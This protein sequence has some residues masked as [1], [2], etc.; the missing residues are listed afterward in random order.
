M[1]IGLKIILWIMGIWLALLIILQIVLTTPVLTKIVNSFAAEYIDGDVRFGKVSISMF[2]K[3]PRAELTFEDFSITYPSERYENIKNEGAQGYLMNEGCG[4]TADTLASFSHLSASINL[5][6]LLTGE[7]KIPHLNLDS[8]RIFIHRYA[9]GSANWDVF[10]LEESED[11]E[12]TEIPD[13]S[14]G[15]IAL[16]KHPYIVYTDSKD[17]LF[18][19]ISSKHIQMNGDLDIQNFSERKVGLSIDSTFIAGRI[20]ADTLALGI[21]RLHLHENSRERAVDINGKLGLYARTQSFGRL[22]VPVDIS[23]N[24]SFPQNE[25]PSVN[26]NDLNIKLAHIPVKANGELVF[27]EDRTTTHAT[28]EIPECG[29]SELKDKFI[30]NFIPEAAKIR[31]DAKISM[32]FLCEGDYIYETG[33]LPPILAQFRLPRAE[34]SHSDIPEEVVGIAFEANAETDSKG[35]LSVELTELQ[36]DA[37]GLDLFAS[38]EMNDVLHSDPKISIDGGIYAN[39]DSLK[40]FIPDSLGIKAHGTLTALVNGDARLSQLNLYNFSESSLKGDLLGENI[41]LEMPEDSI[42]A[43][44]QGLEA[45]LGPEEKTSRRDASKTIQLV[46]IQVKAAKLD[47][48]YGDIFRLNTEG[49]KITAKNTTSSPTVVNGR[50]SYP[51]SGTIS[52]EKFRFRDSDSTAIVLRNTRNRFSIRQKKDKFLTPVLTLTSRNDRIFAR[53]EAN[54]AMLA[55]AHIRVSAEIKTKEKKALKEAYLDSLAK[56]YP[57]IQRDS[58][59]RHNMAQKRAGFVLPDWLSEK[60]FRE[61]DIDIALNKSIARYFREWDISGSLKMS[62]GGI[63]TP[64]FPMQTKLDTF[65]LRF[66]NDKI[67]IDKARVVA[68]ASELSAH[69]K[70]T[71]LQRAL[72]GRKGAL[73]LN[74]DIA[75]DS[76]DAGELLVAYA[77][78]SKVNIE[79]IKTEDQIS[80]SDFTEELVMDTTDIQIETPLIVIPA[81]LNA[82]ISLNARGLRYNTLNIDSLQAQI[83]M[84]ER[85]VQLTDTHAATSIGDVSLEGFYGTRTKQDLKTGFSAEIKNLTAERAINLIPSL[86]TLVP[87]LKS[88]D[89]LLDCEIAATTQFDTDMNI[90]TPTMNGVIRLTGENLSITDNEYFTDLAKTFMFKNKKQTHVD[91]MK[92]EG[93]IKDN[94]LEVFPF[95]LDIDRYILG[96]SGVQG[97]DMSYRYHVSLIKSPLLFKVGVDLYGDDFDNMR[98]K[99]GKAKY[100]SIDVPMF[101]AV[102][103]KT[104]INLVESINNIFTKGVEAAVNEN[105]RQIEISEHKEKIGYVQAVEQSM[106]ELTEEEKKQ[107]ETELNIKI[108]EKK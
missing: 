87:L 21:D 107:V 15:E 35:K 55:D 60:D 41:I 37:N 91:K 52:A 59:F 73:K 14:F 51:F 84:K 3:F 48:S 24:I 32:L 61:Q 74:L 72:L 64:Y 86:D 42:S 9:D 82:D 29:I 104:K 68:G 95:I 5:A 54:K 78:G 89:G 56:R 53:A 65:D 97:L 8:P 33:S 26:I 63:R 43:K 17:T 69:G 94:K 103:D 62:R 40:R 79:D 105:S 4:E 108:F 71:G 76:L 46:G 7:I 92:I 25:D 45:F 93:I 77:A 38:G 19:C 85:C 81:N 83:I 70:L 27:K 57:G 44:I 58:L 12:E 75:S 30:V 47:A 1:K 90:L 28:I 20:V 49:F 96:L 67:E 101:T 16:S 2:S 18:A 31:T 13:I 23:G 6:A 10:K 98:F 11:E 36:A 100:K 66:T 34:I 50:K 106:E 102:I 80:D 22:T 99:I 88:F 39:L